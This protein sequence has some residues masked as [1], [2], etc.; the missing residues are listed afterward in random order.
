MIGHGGPPSSSPLAALCLRVGVCLAV[1]GLLPQAVAAD[2]VNMRVRITWGG[3]GAQ[4]WHGTVAVNK[5]QVSNF[6]ALGTQ[7]DEPGSMWIQD[8]VLNFS[9]RSPR[10]FDGVDLDVTAS[11]DETL[12]VELEGGDEALHVE[13]I[14]IPLRSLVDDTFQQNLDATGNRLTAR[15]APGDRLQVTFDRDALLYRSGETFSCQIAPRLVGAAADATLRY[16]LQLREANTQRVWWIDEIEA[17]AGGADSATA[18]PIELKLPVNEGV[19]N[20]EIELTTKRTLLSLGQKQTLATRSVQLMVLGDVPPS[21]DAPPSPATNLVL[22]ID[23]CKPRWWERIPGMPAVPGLRRGSFGTGQ[24]HTWQHPLGILVQLAAAARTSGPSW[25]AYPL[26]VHRLGQ[27]HVVEIEYPSDVPQTVAVSLVESAGNAPPSSLDSGYSVPD[28]AAASQPQMLVHRLIFWPRTRNPL[29]VLAN[30]REDAQAVYGKIRVV[31]YSGGLPPANGPAPAECRRMMAGYYHRPLFAQ[32]FC[33]PEAFDAAVGRSLPD[34]CTFYLGGLRLIEYLKH[35]GYDGLMLSVLADGA[36]IYPSSQLQ[37]ALHYDGG[38]LF[39]NGQDPLRKDVVELMLRMFD[40]E[41][42]KLIP[43]IAFNAPLPAI[44]DLKRHDVG[45]TSGVEWIGPDGTVRHDGGGQIAGTAAA[46]NPL[47]PE[48]Q[49]AMLAVVDEVLDRYAGHRS[50]AGLA[51]QL[52]ADGYAQLPGL[53]WGFDD[54]TVAA[55]EHDT[56][57]KLAAAGPRRFAARA[58][59]LLG[60]NRKAWAEWRCGRMTAFFRRLQER[61]ESARSDALLYLAGAELF[62]SGDLR[63]ALRPTLPPRPFDD[64][65]LEAGIDPELNAKLPR[66]VLLRPQH[67]RADTQLAS[68]LIDVRINDSLELDRRVRD[69]THPGALFYHQPLRTALPSFDERSAPGGVRLPRTSQIAPSPQ[70]GRQQ[71]VHGLATLDARAMFDGGFLLPLGQDAALRELV[72]LYRKLPAGAWSN[73]ALPTQ[74]V[75]IRTTSHEQQGYIYLA[76]DSPWPVELAVELAVPGG[77]RLVDLR[78]GQPITGLQRHGSH[79]Q[80]RVSLRPYDVA[81]AICST[82]NPQIAHAEVHLGADVE[83]ELA[84]RI[85]DFQARA[86]ALQRQPPCD[87]LANASFELPVAAD[88]AIAGWSSEGQ[89]TLAV[90]I[91]PRKASSGNQSL[92]VA[93][94]GAGVALVSDEF[95]IPAT[96]RMQIA[97]AL[98]GLDDGR[99]VPLRLAIAGVHEGQPFYRQAA[100]EVAPDEP[101]EGGEWTTYVGRFDQMPLDGQAALRIRLELLGSA[102]FW[103][104]DVR[105][106]HLRFSESERLELFKLGTSAQLKLK[107]G[108]ISDCYRLLEGYWPQFLLAYVP[109]TEEPVV[110]RRPQRQAAL[111][112]RPTERAPE[113]NGGFMNRFRQ[114]LPSIWR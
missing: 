81:S 40:R 33:G 87:G 1:L 90:S 62:D 105:L 17:P 22:E 91:D 102:E 35:I 19:Y 11:L 4:R 9:P 43:A 16:A 41:N 7:A 100:L 44:E 71:L 69:A 86:I 93:S 94:G 70:R 112:Q 68:R 109:L 3:G 96:G 52:S 15:R 6:V 74:P 46:Y 18:I 29:L 31:A 73:V 13:S 39:S 56:G 48:V 114:M 89:S 5:G 88:G 99:Q 65:L 83:A 63:N 78:G 20:F 61:I 37:S 107:D 58:Q 38:I 28:E 26:A 14:E 110:Q 66:L 108:Q 75:T 59:L 111:P 101:A 77:T 2:A 92:K 21:S 72:Q 27:P 12:V 98:T 85:Q 67:I 113:K 97:L 54:Q 32:S 23:P 104:D 51:L 64:A 82:A 79:L 57:I 10:T 84:S 55:F 95:Q 47:H 30:P 45:R 49:D 8:N 25:E 42:L 53:A 76:N 34:W 103:I 80:W 60:P 50:F 36:A 24:L 106:Y